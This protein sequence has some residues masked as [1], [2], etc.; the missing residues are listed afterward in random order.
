MVPG[1]SGTGGA[2]CLKEDHSINFKET[3]GEG[4]NN[5]VDI[6]DHESCS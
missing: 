3:L 4:T 2:L 6:N 5:W 1:M